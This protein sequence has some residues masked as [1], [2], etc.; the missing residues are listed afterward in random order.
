[1]PAGPDVRLSEVIGA[2]S[3]A[4]DLTEGE[5]AGHAVRSCLIGMRVAEE[6]RLS[7][8][9]R[10]DLFYALLLKDAG[11]TTNS[12]RM[13]A[14]FGA[15]DHAAKH[16]SKRIDWARPL[17]AF[18]W[19]A[20]TV[21]PG[22]SLRTR[23]AHLLAIKD[24]GEVTRSL[25]ETRCERGAEIALSIGLSD[26]TAE[27]IRTLDEHWDGRGQPRGLAG[28][29]I[30]LLGRILCLAQTVEI[31]NSTFGNDGAYEVARRRSG[32]W[33][34]P[35][36][37]A[38]L[39]GFR[40]DAVFWESLAEPDLARWEPA[41]R[42]MTADPGRVDR[43]ASAFAAIVDAKSP[44]TYSHS[45][46]TR[47]GATS[48]AEVLGFDA[49]DVS[50]LGHA[51]LLH[52]IGKLSLSNRILDKPARLSSA[53][54]ERVKEHPLFTQWVLDRVSC[55]RDVSAVAVAHHE[56]LD[57]S[58]YPRGLVAADLTLPMRVLAV[59][60]VHEALTA[61]RPYRP[62]LD[63]E[64]ALAVM[65]LDVPGRL[66]ADAFEALETVLERQAAR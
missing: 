30:P 57:G 18:L 44:W 46:R 28:D 29:E 2:L 52:D 3:Y 35:A 48:I 66:D 53:E 10:S 7:T 34:D 63:S 31:F 9:S 6:L 61:N 41:D 25:M 13:A 1:M 36:L 32:H 23:V 59:A 11:C 17:P 4:L 20:R 38:A 47:A 64:D 56:R 8:S 22:A 49:E 42:V 43:I 50:G 51:A 16:T 54:F 27:A 62:A 58:G 19:S 55:F 40:G 39:D 37:V 45:E 26:P 33:F 65:R 60:D 14:L 15:D 24:E 12:A 5:P 21:A